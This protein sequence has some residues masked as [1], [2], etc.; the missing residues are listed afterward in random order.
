MIERMVI[1]V[2]SE[3]GYTVGDLKIGGAP[4]EHGGQ[5]AECITVKLVG[6]AAKIGQVKNAPNPCSFKCCI[7]PANATSLNRQVEVTASPPPGM[8]AAFFDEGGLPNLTPKTA[9][10]VRGTRID[11]SRAGGIVK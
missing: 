3:S 8:R 5:I 4:I 6:A 1:E 9:Q 10:S 11:R 2:P 7:D